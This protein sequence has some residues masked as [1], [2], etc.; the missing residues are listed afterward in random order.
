MNEFYNFC[1]A[2]DNKPKTMIN[3]LRNLRKLALFTKK[4]FKNVTKKDIVN[5]LANLR[6]SKN[7]SWGKEG[8][9]V[10]INY[11]N[12]VRVTL[13]KFFKWLYNTG[14]GYP[15]V[16]D[17]IETHRRKLN[18]KLPEEMI[19]LQEVKAM[20]D[21]ASFTRDKAIISVLYE[22]GCRAGEVLSLQ[23]KHLTF[24]RYGAVIMVNGKTGMRRIRLVDSSPYLRKWFNEHPYKEDPEKHLF[25][26]LG[27][28]TFGK[29]MGYF[30]LL[31]LVKTLAKRAGIK[32]RIYPHLF[33]HSRLTEL[34]KIF[35]EQELKVWSGWTGSSYMPRIYV[36]LSGED[37]EKKY[38]EKLGVITPEEIEKEKVEKEVLRPRKCPHCEEINPA[39]SKFCNKCS[40]PLDIKT[41]IEGEMQYQSSIANPDIINVVW[42]LLKLFKP[43]NKEAERKINKLLK[44]YGMEYF[45]K[46]KMDGKFVPMLDQSEKKSS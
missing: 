34:A 15:K 41:A 21:K 11:Q 46:I 45:R 2:Q 12:E 16:V 5:F 3:Y 8:E 27:N 40:L 43:K 19:T 6:Y 7:T 37:I 20:I 32:K 25:I 13:K 28:R 4:S 29:G 39:T 26:D 17:W 10:S 14:K 42:D 30:D 31:W 36:H 33:R 44:K 35:T 1:I 38:L 24:D 23:I 9:I 18:S 22:S